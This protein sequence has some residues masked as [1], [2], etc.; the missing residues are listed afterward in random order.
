LSALGNTTRATHA[1][2]DGVP[3]NKNGMWDLSGYEIPWPGHI[4]LPANER[5]N[6]Q[7]SLTIEFGMQEDEAQQLIDDYWSRVEELG[8]G[9]TLL[10]LWRKHGDH[11]QLKQGCKSEGES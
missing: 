11:D 5:C 6:C 4:D 7:C 10:D 2:L 3:E 9:T 1:E 8:K